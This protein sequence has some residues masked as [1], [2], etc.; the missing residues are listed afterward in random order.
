MDRKK[1]D[2]AEKIK[3]VLAA[4]EPDFGQWLW[5]TLDD[6]TKDLLELLLAERL[7]YFSKEREKESPGDA[8][9]E[10]EQ[11]HKWRELFTGKYPEMEKDGSDFLDWLGACQGREIED[12]YRFGIKEGIH[13]AKWI[14]LA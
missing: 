2:N 7:S 1:G 12:V 11:F 3:E 14:F 10:Q 6:E 13:I 4:Q 9:E 8:Q 5:D